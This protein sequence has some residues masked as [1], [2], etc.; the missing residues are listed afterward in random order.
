[1]N[2]ISITDSDLRYMVNE[3]IEKMGNGF[4][5]IDFPIDTDGTI[6]DDGEED[7]ELNSFYDAIEEL[8]SDGIMCF[9]KIKEML[10]EEDY[11]KR[12]AEKLKTT[13]DKITNICNELDAFIN[14]YGRI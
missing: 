10:T 2:K 9:R 12:N 1:M 8:A 6:D 3:A 14:D 5:N 13:L 4:D 7:A 11:A